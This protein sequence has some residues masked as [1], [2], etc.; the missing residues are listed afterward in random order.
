MRHIKGDDPSIEGLEGCVDIRNPFIDCK[1]IEKA[2]KIAGFKFILPKK[3]PKGYKI[4]EIQAIEKEL[5]QVMYKKGDKE[6]F[7]RK[8]IG[9]EDLSGDY[10][11]YKK[12][13]NLKV[14][15]IKVNTKEEKTKVKVATWLDKG[16]SFA[17]LADDIDR[18]DLKI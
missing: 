3:L 1:T 9:S 2:E 6:I 13:K 5:I 18:K 12:G 8:G 11:V 14:D 10:N 7:I 17:I 4:T 15:N 16:Y